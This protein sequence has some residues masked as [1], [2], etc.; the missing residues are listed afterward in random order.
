MQR[1]RSAVLYSVLAAP[2]R[3]LEKPHSRINIIAPEPLVVNDKFSN[4]NVPVFRP[5]NLF[6]IIGSKPDL[7][8][9]FAS[10]DIYLL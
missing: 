10:A 8:P 4:C 3:I 1:I 5:R 6:Q 2:E 7:H 9:K